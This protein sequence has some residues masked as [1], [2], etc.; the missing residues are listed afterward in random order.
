MKIVLSWLMEFCPTELGPEELAELL[1]SR[2]AKVEDIERP[3]DRLSGVTVARVVEVRDH[4]ASDKLC[5]ARVTT[6][7]TEREVV[8]GVRNMAPGDL[9]PLAG[10]GATLPVLPEPLAAR[11]IRG[12]VSDGMLCSPYELGIS[13][14]HEAILVLPPGPSPGDDVRAS[15]GLDDPV[16]DIE[17]TPNRPDFLS[18][19]GVARE[20]AAATGTPF[21]P[22]DTSLEE[23]DEKANE[24][25]TVEVLDPE[26][27]PRYVARVLRGIRHVDAPL[28]AQA[29]LTASGMRPIS[30][31]VDATNYAMLE[32]GQP[33][34]PFDLDLLAG[35]G[36]VVREATVGER[37]VTLDGVERTFGEDDL[38]ICDT[39][40]PVAVAG[41]MGGAIA[42][43]S[44]ST[45]DVLL[46][47][48]H[49]ERAGIQRT[50]RR[51]NLSTEASVRF[52]RGIDPEAVL[53]GADR[54]CRLMAEWCGARALSGVLDVGAV[55]ERRHI[56]MRPSRATMLLG[57]E[58]SAS[59]AK[60]VFDRLAMASDMAEDSL[61]VEVPGY[62]VD[63]ER[64]VDLIEEVVRIQ[65]YDRVR[66]GLPPVRQAGGLPET[67]AFTRLARRSLARAGLREV[68]LP[69][70]ASSEDAAMFGDGDAVGIANPLDASEDRLR[71]RL[72][73]GLL[74]AVARN[75]SRQVRTVA[76][77]EVGTVFHRADPVEER[78][79]V[80]LAMSGPAGQSWLEPDRYLDFFDAKGAV[81]ALLADAGARDWSLGGVPG[82][83]F[84][85]GRGAEVLLGDDP[86][87]VVAEVHPAVAERLDIPDRVAV[88][89][90]DLETLLARSSPDLVAREPSRFPPVRR[91]LAFIV[92]ESVAA[93]G[94]RLA[95]VEA[96]GELVESCLLFD[97]FTGGQLPEGKKSLAFSLDLRAVDRTLTEQEAESVVAGM[98]ERVGTDFGAELRTG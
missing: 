77:F 52:E 42:E 3:W 48:A 90:L 37:L 51:I 10:P 71:T 86:V 98:V 39:E 72:L 92:D 2:G 85:P 30:A 58:V 25:A 27:C 74:R 45:T 56:T 69:S 81:E 54:A 15:L 40:R 73:P 57:Y 70:F 6:G 24:V 13:P 17:V 36:I 66:S 65:G 12:V 63:L 75:R 93:E 79:R 67:Y 43:M 5:L 20:V 7:S 89:E 21:R 76:I 64:E 38:L 97:V 22:P 28:R 32:V 53:M 61:V 8:V 19:I 60:E 88:A 46:E 1:T 47:S 87:G 94:F 55:P 9:V 83:P 62:R 31:A 23:D 18:V 80:A 95:L 44:E 91:D 59:G 96:G 16:L 84:H 11:E 49:F 35:P 33:L 29:R 34:H 78:L 26:R 14:N 4:P 68:R 41:V 82:G 50:R